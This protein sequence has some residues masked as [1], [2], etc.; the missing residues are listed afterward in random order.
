MQRITPEPPRIEKI[1]KGLYRFTSI[2]CGGPYS[3]GGSA[4]GGTLMIDRCGTRGWALWETY[5][6]KCLCCDCNGHA[7]LAEC[8]MYSPDY[9][10]ATPTQSS[11]VRH[12]E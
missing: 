1:S 9:F 11:E 3:R 8:V 7:T 2:V 12:G 10:N 6:E 4:C 5:C